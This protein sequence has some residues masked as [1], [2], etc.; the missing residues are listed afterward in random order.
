MVGAADFNGPWLGFRQ[1]A[2]EQIGDKDFWG[3]PDTYALERVH[4]KV[5]ALTGIVREFRP[6]FLFYMGCF[7]LLLLLLFLFGDCD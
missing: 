5:G 3:H 6:C 4:L 1:W 2:L 7:L